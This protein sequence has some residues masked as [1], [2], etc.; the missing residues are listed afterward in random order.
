ML[1]TVIFAF[2]ITKQNRHHLDK[3]HR[4]KYFHYRTKYKD[5]E[6]MRSIFLT[7]YLNTQAHEAERYRQKKNGT[8]KTFVRKLST[9]RISA[10]GSMQSTLVH[11]FK[12]NA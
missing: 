2:F 6:R 11:F 9:F 12:K 10:R 5:V 3:N 4:S 1:Q 8:G 7:T